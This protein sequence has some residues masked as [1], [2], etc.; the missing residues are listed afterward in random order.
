MIILLLL[1]YFI[2]MKV[3]SQTNFSMRTRKLP[4]G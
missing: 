4:F 1:D 3:N 2:L